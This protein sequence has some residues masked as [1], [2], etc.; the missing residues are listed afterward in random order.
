MAS[1]VPAAGELKIYPFGEVFRIGL[2]PPV[3]FFFLLC[4]RKE[5]M[6]W[7]GL[8]TAMA[9]VVVRS[10]LEQPLFHIEAV[11]ASALHHIPAFVYYFSYACL[12]RFSQLKR[13]ENQPIK[14]GLV[15]LGIDLASNSIE[16]FVDSLLFAI[17]LSLDDVIEIFLIAFARGFIVVSLLTMLKLNDAYIREK[18]ITKQHEHM[19]MLVS[20]LY[21]ETIYLK[22]TLNDAEEATK[23]SYQLYR[24]LKQDNHEASQKALKLAGKIHDIKKDNQRIFAGLSRVI[25]NESPKDFMSAEELLQLAVQINEKYAASLKKDILFFKMVSGKHTPYHAY[26][27]LSL[28]NNLVSNGVEA[29]V[30]QGTI[31]IHLLSRQDWIELQVRNS[32]QPI[33]DKYTEVIFEPG[34]TTKYDKQ[35]NPSTG[36]GLAHVREI[37]N[38]S[39]GNI[40]VK[41]EPDGV[42]FRI[43]IPGRSFI[44][45]G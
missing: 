11:F 18:H 35:G 17:T 29:I 1:A 41:N 2:G 38:G 43:R 39:G 19:L 23:E 33:A 20:N 9:V 5:R 4:I 13:Y 27:F 34:F 44:E 22:K 32:G 45:K 36:I 26:T 25:T 42:L 21:E 10:V 31:E 37:V 40:A 8:I 15:M 16:L 7:A 14:I 3:M 28:V 6:V 12:C 30:E 24:S